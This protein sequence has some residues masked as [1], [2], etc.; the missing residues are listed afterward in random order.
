MRLGM[1]HRRL[2][3]LGIAAILSGLVGC[4]MFQEQA[5]PT[6]NA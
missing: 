2:T 5:T 4:S 1:Q 6:L 3:V